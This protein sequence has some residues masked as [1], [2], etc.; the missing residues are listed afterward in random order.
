MDINLVGGLN[1][2]EKYESIGMMTF[3]IY[4]KIKNDLKPPNRRSNNHT[5]SGWYETQHVQIYAH[6]E[7]YIII[8]IYYDS[9]MKTWSIIW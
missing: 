4:G 1:P 5:P 7:M 6:I 9:D 2:S 8:M 3:P